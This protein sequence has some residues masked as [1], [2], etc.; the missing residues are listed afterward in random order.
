MCTFICIHIVYYGII[1]YHALV[2]ILLYSKSPEARLENLE[3]RVA[4][5][6]VELRRRLESLERLSFEQAAQLQKVNVRYSSLQQEHAMLVEQMGAAGPLQH[7]SVTPPNSGRQSG[8]RV[9]VRM[10]PTAGAAPGAALA[11]VRSTLRQSPAVAGVVPIPIVHKDPAGHAAAASRGASPG[12]SAVSTAAPPQTPR[13]AAQSAGIYVVGGHA[14]GV[15]LAAVDRLNPSGQWEQLPPMPTPRHG[16]AAAS[17]IGILYVF[18]GANDGGMPLGTAE[19]FDPLLGRWERL[20]PAPTARH[21]S[22]CAAAAGKLFCVGG[23]DGEGVLSVAERFDP[24]AGSWERLPPM[25]TARGRCM[26]AALEGLIYVAGG[27]DDGGQELTSFECID[28]AF[29][30]WRAPAPPTPINNP[31]LG[32]QFLFTC[33]YQFRRRHTFLIDICFPPEGASFCCY[34]E[35]VAHGIR[36]GSTSQRSDSKRYDKRQPAI[37]KTHDTRHVTLDI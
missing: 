28:A 12:V 9:A 29:C 34:R 25:P 27:T 3:R 26:A 17:V 21:G 1:S 31:P 23:Y 22:A 20:P 19:R 16:C 24:V 5:Q 6:D 11:N 37:C 36:Q 7:P 14:S 15:T 4:G 13:V 35:P 8:A 32:E 30:K 33:Y 18:G 2:L 10:E